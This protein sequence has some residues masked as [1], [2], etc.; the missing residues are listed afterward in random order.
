MSVKAESAA[1]AVAS[2]DSKMIAM[3]VRRVP[4]IDPTIAQVTSLPFSVL[5]LLLLIPTSVAV[6]M[7]TCVVGRAFVLRFMSAGTKLDKLKGAMRS[8]FINM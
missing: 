4:S 3:L 5:V 7:A 6:A 1:A 2:G 8:E